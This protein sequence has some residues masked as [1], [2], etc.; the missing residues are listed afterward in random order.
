MN[1]VIT[2]NA[3]LQHER[4]LMSWILQ[5]VQLKLDHRIEEREDSVQV[6]VLSQ[7]YQGLYVVLFFVHVYSLFK[8]KSSWHELAWLL[9][10]LSNEFWDLL[11]SYYWL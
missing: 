6:T 9:R 1:Y 10:L 11:V 2:R 3:Q 7:F 8:L 5:K 4:D